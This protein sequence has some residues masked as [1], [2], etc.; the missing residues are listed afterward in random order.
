MKAPLKMKNLGYY[1]KISDE[2]LLQRVTNFG[3]L[4][5]NERE[6]LKKRV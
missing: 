4:K 6:Y 2:N 1:L 5:F 3:I